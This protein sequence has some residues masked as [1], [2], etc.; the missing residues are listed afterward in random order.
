[1]YRPGSPTTLKDWAGLT[2]LKHWAGPTILMDWGGQMIQ[3]DWVSP[4][5]R[6]NR[7][8]WSIQIR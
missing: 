2:T 1:M 8:R 4:T 7:A 3:T 6:M 5:T